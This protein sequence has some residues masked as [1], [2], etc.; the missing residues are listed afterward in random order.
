VLCCAVLCCAVLCCAVLCCAVLR[1]DA[2]RCDAMRCDA[3]RC[4]A[5]RGL[6]R[7][8]ATSGGAAAGLVVL[9]PCG[10][11]PDALCW[12]MLECSSA[13][14]SWQNHGPAVCC[15]WLPVLAHAGLCGFALR[16]AAC[17]CLCWRMLDC[18]PD[19]SPLAASGCVWLPLAA[20]GCLWLPVAACG[21]LCLPLAACCHIG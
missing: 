16:C 18:G 15:L 11:L 20:S 7:A 1:C 2:M 13:A 6:P 3:M 12:S 21:C 14:T 9:V 10:V 17:G 19:A 8:L 4:D 5:M